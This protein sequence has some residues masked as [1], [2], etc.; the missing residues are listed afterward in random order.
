MFPSETR[1]LLVED[2]TITLRIMQKMFSQLGFTQVQAC[3][4]GLEAREEIERGL[5]LGKPY[6]LVIADW[7]MPGVSGL[8]LLKKMRA[9]SITASVPFILLSSNSEK[10]RVLE[11]MRSGVSAY[12]AKPFSVEMLQGKMREAWEA[13]QPKRRTA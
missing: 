9:E 11:A 8:G 13:T 1:I 5:G 2:T 4:N 10:D 6:G 12:L 3:S 7:N